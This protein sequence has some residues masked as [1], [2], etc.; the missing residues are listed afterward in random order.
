MN[1]SDQD[2]PRHGFTGAIDAQGAV[3]MRGVE[4]PQCTGDTQSVGSS[5]S[6][7]HPDYLDIEAAGCWARIRLPED[8]DARAHLIS[9]W[10]H[11]RA[12]DSPV[13]Q[14]RLA[15]VEQRMSAEPSIVVGPPTSLGPGYDFDLSG[16]LTL[17]LLCHLVG[18]RL[19]LHAGVVDVDDLGPVLLIG[20]SGAGKSTATIEL[21]RHGLYLTDE[22]ACL[23]PRTLAVEAYAKPISRVVS[24]GQRPTDSIRSRYKEDFAPS[25]LGMRVGDRASAPVAVVLLERSDHHQ[26][27]PVLTSASLM[28]ALPFIVSQSSSVWALPDALQLLV[29]LCRGQF[30]VLKAS[31]REAGDLVTAL[32]S[33]LTGAPEQMWEH[34][35]LSQAVGVAAGQTT[36]NSG[37]FSGTVCSAR[38]I[39]SAHAFG[40][41][42]TIG[43]AHPVEPSDSGTETIEGKDLTG[44]SYQ[45]LPFADAGLLPEGL[46]I[47]RDSQVI[48]LSGAGA[49]VWLSLYEDGVLSYA[50]LLEYAL[51]S[52]EDVPPAL[53]EDGLRTALSSLIGN[54]LA[55]TLPS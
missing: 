21:A 44:C 3:H 43:P 26:G 55:T 47:L 46:M 50:Q 53:I 27:P 31:Y 12:A 40:L 24:E 51:N 34:L 30:G 22:M 9:L 14:G 32:R 5:D 11:L 36:K 41:A 4:Y 19:L 35:P 23:D 15:G 16:Q 28:E 54:R 1:H 17:E 18:S 25:A 20:P 52:G 2:P 42:G 10:G 8:A 29:R 45:L 7:S 33:S 39:E 49:A 6:L 13:C 37:D 38:M 48:T